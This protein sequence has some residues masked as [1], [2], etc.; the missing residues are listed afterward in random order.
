MPHLVLDGAALA[1]RA[2][3]AGEAVI[4]IS[5]H[6]DRGARAVADALHERRK[7]RMRG[8]PRFEMFSLPERF[9]SGQSSALVNA[10][11]RGPGKPSFA[12]ARS[13]A[14]CAAGPHSCRTSRRSRTWR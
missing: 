1:A 2:V 9:V 13:S 7:A 11:S 6:D 14:V 5:E 12:P 10:I 3:D 4:A 8:E